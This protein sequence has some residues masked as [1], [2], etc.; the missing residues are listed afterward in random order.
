MSSLTSEILKSDLIRML[1]ENFFNQN[2]Q[3]SVFAYRGY[4]HIVGLRHTI[5]WCNTVATLT[6][7]PWR[8]P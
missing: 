6:T 1:V 8:L 5:G 4:R 2:L 7:N 3:S